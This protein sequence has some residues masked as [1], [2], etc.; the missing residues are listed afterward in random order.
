MELRRL[1]L[2]SRYRPGQDLRAR[3]G[4][5]ATAA[6]AFAARPTCPGAG[7]DGVRR[8]AGRRRGGGLRSVQSATWPRFTGARHFRAG[9]GGHGRGKQQHG[10]RRRRQARSVAAGQPRS[11][12]LE[13]AR[14][15]VTLVEPGPARRGRR[16]PSAFA[17]RLTSRGAAPTGVTAAAAATSCSSATRRAAIWPRFA[18]RRTSAPGAA[19]WPGQAQHGARGEDE[20][21][22]PVPPGTQAEGLDGGAST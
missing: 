17:A 10:A 3:A 2:H 18:A 1:A 13:L 11:R 9:R 12:R 5:A 21:V 6:S 20:V 4:A 8:G 14:A 19:P 16:R 7:P 15:H 22:I